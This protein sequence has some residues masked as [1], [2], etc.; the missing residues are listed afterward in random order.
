VTVR[1]RGD[2]YAPNLLRSL[3]TIGGDLSVTTN[4]GSSANVLVG[5]EA[6]GASVTLAGLD[7]IGAGN[8]LDALQ[9]V[10]GSSSCFCRTSYRALDHGIHAMVLMSAAGAVMLKFGS[11]RPLTLAFAPI[12]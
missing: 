4:A 3:K 9:S 5:L 11:H 12:K 2:L 8:V 1:T 6:V 10:G 7:I